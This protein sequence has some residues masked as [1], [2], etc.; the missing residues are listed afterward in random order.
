MKKETIEEFLA[1][2]GKINKITERRPIKNM[3]RSEAISFMM[4]QRP[5]QKTPPLAL[6]KGV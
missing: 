4:G 6:P 5:G 1:R 2:G 3:T